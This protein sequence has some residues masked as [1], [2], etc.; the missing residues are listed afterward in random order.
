MDDKANNETFF[1]EIGK[2]KVPYVLTHLQGTPATMQAN[3]SYYDVVTQVKEYFKE[4]IITLKAAGIHDIIIDPG[5]GFG[6]TLAH[7]YSLLKHLNEFKELGY[8]ILAGISRKSMIHQLIEV[9]PATALNGTTVA[10]TIALLH[11]AGLLRVHDVKEAKEA[12][13]IINF[14]KNL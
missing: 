11:G 9:T 2:Q 13:K 5:F 6:K 1:K 12:V 7:N 14:I 3:P 4:K 8:P 10:H